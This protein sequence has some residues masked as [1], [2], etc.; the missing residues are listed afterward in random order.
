MALLLNELNNCCSMITSNK[1]T[2]ERKRY[3]DVLYTL[4]ENADLLQIL[5]KDENSNKWDVLIESV[6]NYLVREAEKLNDDE[7]KRDKKIVGK[8]RIDVLVLTVSKAK[9][10][11]AAKLD[12]EKLIGIVIDA[13]DTYILRKYYLEKY[14]LILH[15]YILS[16]QQYCSKIKQQQWMDLL[17]T[18]KDLNYLED[19]KVLGCI[20]LDEFDF[21]SRLGQ[22]LNDSQSKRYK[23][24][25]SSDCCLACCKLGEDVFISLRSIY[26]P[27]T[28]DITIKVFSWD[29]SNVTQVINQNDTEDVSR[30]KRQRVEVSLEEIFNCINETQAW[31]WIHIVTE[32]LRKYPASLNNDQFHNLFKI[33]S[34]I[35]QDSQDQDVIKCCYEALDVLLDVEANVTNLTEVANID[36]VYESTLRCVGLNHNVAET[37]RLLRKMLTRGKIKDL[38]RLYETFSSGVLVLSDHSLYTLKMAANLHNIPETINNNSFRKTIIEWI[39]NVNVHKCDASHVYTEQITGEVLVK[40]CLKKWTEETESESTSQKKVYNNFENVYEYNACMKLIVLPNKISKSETE[41]IF[42]LNEETYSFLFNQLELIA[43]DSMTKQD[44]PTHTKD[45]F[46]K[47]CLFAHVLSTLERHNLLNNIEDIL[48]KIKFADIFAFLCTKL[49]NCDELEVKGNIKYYKDFL[50]DFNQFLSIEF[51]RSVSEMIRTLVSVDFLRKFFEIINIDS[52]DKISTTDL[53]DLKLLSMQ[54]LSNFCFYGNCDVLS[55]TQL[56]IL[57]ALTETNYDNNDDFDYKMVTTFL[58]HIQQCT[59]AIFNDE[60]LGKILNLIQDVCYVRFAE[61]NAVLNVLSLLKELVKHIVISKNVNVRKNYINLLC[62]FYELRTDYGYDVSLAIIECIGSIIE[63]S[64]NNNTSLSNDESELFALLPEFLISHYQEVRLHAI[65]YISLIFN[66]DSLVDDTIFI[67]QRELFKAI[68]VKCHEVFR[69]ETNNMSRERTIDETVA[70]SSS[71]LHTYGSLIVSSST[72]RIK[73]LYFLIQFVFDKK[74][75]TNSLDRILNLIA[76]ELKFVGKDDFLSSYVEYLLDEWNSDDKDMSEFPYHL[77]G[78]DSDLAFYEKYTHIIIPL[79]VVKRNTDFVKNIC[80]LLK[81]TVAEIYELYFSEIFAG[82]YHFQI[83]YPNI[84]ISEDIKDTLTNDRVKELLLQNVDK[85]IVHMT[86]T[87]LDEK[88][89]EEQF[90]M[91]FK[92]LKYKDDNSLKNFDDMMY[93]LRKDLDLPVPVFESLINHP[94]KIQSIMLCLVINI[95][96]KFTAEDRLKALHQYVACVDSITTSIDRIITI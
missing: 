1:I 12:C 81:K 5:N 67:I 52:E 71:V 53:G 19:S 40:L 14:L 65:R 76:I 7:R 43:Q 22:N 39:L 47:L 28:S 89:F 79:S 33:I 73:L 92:L 32:Y 8:P 42:Y 90:S 31:Q 23:I 11:C 51:S 93:Q 96:N 49:T 57:E 56:H 80:G 9:L 64:L 16:D 35:L 55:E 72:W 68:N 66:M 30:A 70:R 95:H 69:I 91:P 83:K 34:S 27:T 46:K 29:S 38:D 41:K 85:I 94:G 59:S 44:H 86:K 74:I 60:I 13:L 2:E 84:K 6:H 63:V 36:R 82:I 88:V 45:L 17:R 50:A 61:Y 54:I 58:T 3:I 62:Q 25:T 20:K 21:V 87:I 15:D 75:D 78:Y 37:H 24:E 4:L 18:L 48:H 77:L 26:Q 10:K